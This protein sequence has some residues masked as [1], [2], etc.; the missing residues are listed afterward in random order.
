MKMRGNKTEAHI[1][2]ALQWF[3]FN[4]SNQ[5]KMINMKVWTDSGSGCFNLRAKIRTISEKWHLKTSKEKFL[6]L[7]GI[8]K[9]MFEV[10]GVRVYGDC[11][12]NLYSQFGNVLVVYY[13]SMV[14]YTIYYWTCKGQFVYGLRCLCGMGI[15]ISVSIDFEKFTNIFGL[16]ALILFLFFPVKFHRCVGSS[17]LLRI[18]WR[19]TF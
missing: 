12:L 10:V 3:H 7:Y 9:W 5:L 15:M 4:R 16:I 2:C 1:I 13:L 19:G 11:H 6:M 18:D 8:P 17:A 14:S